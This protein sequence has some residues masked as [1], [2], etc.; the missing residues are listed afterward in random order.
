MNSDLDDLVLI[1]DRVLVRPDDGEQQTRSGLLLPASVREGERVG[2]GRV[3]AVGPG[4]LTV[5]PEYSEEEEAWR[6]ERSAVRYLPLQAQPGDAAFFLR[7]NAIEVTLGETS[8]LIL[9]HNALLA[10][11]RPGA[12]RESSAGRSEAGPGYGFD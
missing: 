9:P 8:Y 6:G 7:A 12:G 5:N 1:G 2:T 4:H 11:V 10:L 3:M